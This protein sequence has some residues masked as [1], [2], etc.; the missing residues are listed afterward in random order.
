M[1]IAPV[2]EIDGQ[3]LSWQYVKGTVYC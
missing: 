2:C 3:V 1:L